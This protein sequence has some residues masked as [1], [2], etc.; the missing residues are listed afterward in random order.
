M[1]AQHARRDANRAGD[2]PLR[3]LPGYAGQYALAIPPSI[4]DTEAQPSHRAGSRPIR[5]LPVRALGL[6][7]PTGD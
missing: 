5:G 2:Q 4:A 1:A 7:G 3:T 6:A